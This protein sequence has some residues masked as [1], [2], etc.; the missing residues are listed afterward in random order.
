V[1]AKLP[2]HAFA[3]DGIT[4]PLALK[5]PETC[6]SCGLPKA[7]QHHDLPATPAEVVE[8]EARRLGGDR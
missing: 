4:D 7:N 8:A 5:P 1:T 3:W 6:A 2:V